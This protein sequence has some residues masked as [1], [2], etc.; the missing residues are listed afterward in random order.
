M[1]GYIEILIQSILFVFVLK[2]I[3]H[4]VDKRF[5]FDDKIMEMCNKESVSVDDILYTIK[6]KYIKIDLQINEREFK[7]GN[8]FNNKKLKKYVSPEN[9]YKGVLEYSYMGYPLYM[10]FLIINK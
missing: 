8:R 1:L 6:H 7:S 3:E 2:I 10:R 9:S 5:D 4:I